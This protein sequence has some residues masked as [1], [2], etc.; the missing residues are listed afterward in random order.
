M[1]MPD[2]TPLC[3]YIHERALQRDF[4]FVYALSRHFKIA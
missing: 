1:L 2:A 3:K 4:V